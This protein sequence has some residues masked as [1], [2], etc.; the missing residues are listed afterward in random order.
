LKAEHRLRAF[1][2]RVLRKI[3]GSKR[4]EVTGEWRRLHNEELCDMYSSSYSGFTVLS[5]P[6]P[7]P[8]FSIRFPIVETFQ[9]H[10]FLRG[11]VVSPTRN[12]QPAGPGYP[13]LSE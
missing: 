4:D 2:N 6:Y 12:P 8:E 3:F 10:I 9:Q 1:E 11:G 13:F 7:F 5:G